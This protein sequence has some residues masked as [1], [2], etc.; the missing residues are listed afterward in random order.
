MRCTNR[1]LLLSA[2]L[3]PLVSACS[4]EAAQPAPPV[5]TGRAEATSIGEPAADLTTL[6]ARERVA[7][8][9]AGDERTRAREALRPLVERAN[10]ELQDLVAGAAIELADNRVEPCAAFLDRAAKL[11][12][13]S[14]A[15]AYL[16]GQLARNNGEFK[17]ARDAFR[18]ALAG[19]PNDLPTKLA[20]AEAED[21]LEGGAEAERLYREVVAV[22]PAA[23]GTWY[24]AALYRLRTWLTAAGPAR[25]AEAQR[26]DPILRAIEARG[27]QAPSVITVLLGE[28]ARVKP[29]R[30]AGSRVE[31][32]STKFAFLA[33]PEIPL[34]GGTSAILARDV[35]GDNATDIVAR[36]NDV[37][38]VLTNAAG[39]LQ[40][41]SPALEGKSAMPVLFDVDNDGD[42]DL[43]TLQPEGPVLAV[44]GVGGHARVDAQF[45]ESL[46]GITA[47]VASDYDHEGDLDLVLAGAFGVRVWRNDSSFDRAKDGSTTLKSARFVD[48]SAESG[49][50]ASG[51]YTW[52]VAEDFDGDNDVDFLARGPEGVVVL[53]SLRDGKFAVL[54]GLF[55]LPAGLVDEPL[56]A[57]FDGDARPDLW[58]AGTPSTLV[59][60]GKAPVRGGTAHARPGSI[61][62]TDI[63]LDGSLDVLW[64]DVETGRLEG[65]LG[66]GLTNE[67]AL[68]LA[69]PVP[70]GDRLVIADFDGDCRNDLAIEGVGRL[71]IFPNGNPTGR[72]ARL[73]WRGNRDNRRAVGAIVE[74]RAGAIYRRTYWRG[75]PELI[76]IGKATTI[77]VLRVTWPNGVLTTRLDTGIDQCG[78]AMDPAEA[79]GALTQGDGQVGSCPFLYAWN[80]NTFGFVSDVLGITP[81]GLRMAPGMFVPPDHDEYVLVTGEQLAP[82]DGEYVFQF[83]EELREV[84][85]LDHVRL[86]VVDSPVGT[87]ILPN[88]M[89]KFPPFPAARIHA[90]REV[91]TPKRAT[92]SDGR[93]WTAALQE[94]D[95]VFPQPMQLHPA[96]FAG[97][98]QPWFLELEFEPERLRGATELRLALTGW[99][100][101][102]DASANM[103][104]ARSEGVAFVPPMFQVPD[105]KGGWRDTGPPIGFPAGKTKTMV[106]DVAPFLDLADPRIRVATTLRLYWDRI[107]LGIGADAVIETRTLPC[108]KIETWRRGFSAPLEAL[109]PG[110]AN[111]ANRPERFDWNVLAREP[112]WN[113]HPGLY[114]RHGDVTELVREVDDRMVILGAGDAATL[115]F[116]ARPIEPPKPGMRRDFLLYLD[117]WAK[118]RDPNTIEALEV[119]PLPFHGM[120][121]YPYRADEHFP[122]DEAHRTWRREWL[123]RPAFRWIAPVSPARE[124]EWVLDGT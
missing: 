77:D 65:R 14:P 19:A 98:A 35:D 30:P 101:W 71:R 24:V 121:G 109:A 40:A 106:V 80:G 58:F 50:P 49:L 70:T 7:V 27:I 66:V 26:L 53:D 39:V 113:Q 83:T 90:L 116:D 110:E 29:P 82:K 89:F 120:S 81:L 54:R 105:G 95:D 34:P 100:Y 36:A 43:F 123:T 8:H 122:D 69:D 37:I 9:L 3:L 97:L 111:P 63:D 18:A 2:S 60:Q 45:P 99:F 75:E 73:A 51:D 85:Y 46:P 124:I 22:G 4:D 88:E 87:E 118:D 52:I 28:L 78:L 115:R 17:A 119:E 57:D 117:G 112:R 74:L 1:F 15:V 47:V 12:P 92:G 32:S 44:H 23:G 76:G 86:V 33:G 25:E 61:A 103:A 68:A 102:S 48:A 38:S 16:R 84:T 79:L 42:L 94:V 108:A 104:A 31:P 10:P 67:R 114:T 93:D 56:V 91:V 59:I 107:A 20:L 96:Q 64:L 5:A 72:G 62:A 55:A 6:L 11:D 41:G 13:K 21:E